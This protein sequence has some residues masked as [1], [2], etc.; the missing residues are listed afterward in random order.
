MIIDGLCLPMQRTK[1][2][3]LVENTNSGGED[4]KLHKIIHLQLKSIPT[5]RQFDKLH[6]KTLYS[7]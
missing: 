1:L 7:M 2:E 5:I 4:V 6:F 3:L